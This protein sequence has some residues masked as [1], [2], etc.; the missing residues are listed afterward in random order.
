MTN[1]DN[2]NNIKKLPS[3]LEKL[4][5]L[6]YIPKPSKGD[7]STGYITRFF[8]QK[9][10]D[11]SSPI[12]EINANYSSNIESKVYYVLTSLDWRLV[13]ALDE[14][15]KSNAASVRLASADI[16]KIGLYLPNLLQFHKK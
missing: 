5:I 7:Y 10:N 4:K 1:K 14:I 15:K 6:T 9:V 3:G 8:I 16:P 11:I 12:Y 13:G 2:Y